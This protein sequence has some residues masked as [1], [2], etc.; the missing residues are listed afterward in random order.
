MSDISKALQGRMNTRKGHIKEQ[1]ERQL[2]LFSSLADREPSAPRVVTPKPEPEMILPPT[3]T[4]PDVAADVRAVLSE[5]GPARPIE[6]ELEGEDA[7]PLKTG[8]YRRPPRP[9]AVPAPSR[10]AAPT[11]KKW[12]PIQWL[13]DWFSGVELNRRMVALVVVSVGLVALIAF[14]TACPRHEG[15]KPGTTLDLNATPLSPAGPAPAPAI[16][17]PVSPSPSA[18]SA[19][20]VSVPPAMPA[21]DWKIAGTTATRKGNAVQ[22]VFTDPV[23]VSADNISLEGWA[24]L[25]AVAARLAALKTG[26]RVQVTGYTDDVPLSRPTPEFQNNADLAAARARVAVEHLA[27]FS[28]ANKALV[29]DAVAGDPAQAP[30]PNDSPQNRRLNRTVTLQVV[31]AP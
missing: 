12:M 18:A 4:P 25:K 20:A 8:I 26:A 1:S 30:Y 29:Y 13:R 19:A 3:G 24:A 14:W 23:F 17:E 7:R 21:D 6:P 15:P 22:L 16:S 28:R 10:P 27:Q 5:A 31:P 9:A 11:Q 2:D